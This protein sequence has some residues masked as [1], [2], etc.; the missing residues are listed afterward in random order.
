MFVS[1]DTV[2]DVKQ[3]EHILQEA[4][5]N[6]IHAQA[7]QKAAYDKKHFNPE[8]FKVA[9]MVLK[10]DFTRKKRKGGKLDAKWEGPYEIVCSLGRGLYRLR[11]VH[12]PNKFLRVNGV[13]L[14]KY[15]LPSNVS[16]NVHS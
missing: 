14:K 15:I 7:K 3:R 9:S 13:H 11:D 2:F 10:K 5:K 8:V 4:K 16:I 12:H 1:A 6:I